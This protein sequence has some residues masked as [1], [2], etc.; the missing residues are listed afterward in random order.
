MRQKLTLRSGFT[1]VELLIVIVVLG[2]L[3]VVAITSFSG[4][5]D[6]ARTASVESDLRNARS[7]LAAAYAENGVYPTDPS[8]LPISPGT[9]YILESTNAG[10]P[11]FCLQA[12][13]GNV[14]RNVTNSSAKLNTGSII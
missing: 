8:S 6:R 4:A 11:G 10:T 7:K 13:N 2:I 12:T 1:I 5:Q 9:S 3:A 14:T